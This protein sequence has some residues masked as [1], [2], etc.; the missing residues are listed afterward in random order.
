MSLITVTSPRFTGLSLLRAL[1]ARFSSDSVT[2]STQ[3]TLE[4]LL[5]GSAATL[6]TSTS[7]DTNTPL[8]LPWTAAT[9]H[10]VYLPGVASNY[11]S[12]PDAANLDITGD[13]D[14][15]LHVAADDWTPGA[16]Q[17]L[18]AKWDTAGG[19]RSFTVELLDTGNIRLRWSVDGTA[20][21]TEDSSV[22]P[23]LTDGDDLHIRI[24]L[25]AD[26]GSG[27]ADT[28][29]Y[30]STDGST[31]TQLGDVGSKG[32]TTSINSGTAIV[33]VGTRDQSGIP[34]AG[35]VH[36]AQIYSGIDGTKVLDINPSVDIDTSSDADAG[37]ASFTASTG[38]TVTVNRSG[39][40]PTTVVTRPVLLLD[41]GDDLV[42]LPA[43]LATAATE[44]SGKLTAWVAFRSHGNASAGD[45]ILSF[46]N[47]E[48]DGFHL[49][50]SNTPTVRATAG[51]GTNTVAADGATIVSGD[52]TFGALTVSE[53]SIRGYSA[54]TMS[55]ATSMSSVS[56]M[57][58]GTPRVGARAS[59][60]ANTAPI[61]V[62]GFGVLEGYAM[63]EAELEAMDAAIAA[64]A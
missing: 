40:L 54:G 26:N 16:D 56:G 32:A 22:A 20:S 3:Q 8:R 44:A 4:D 36:R 53:G 15:R 30:T 64:G 38:Q 24:T 13:I 1:T 55:A 12:V 63:T 7:E 51:D 21:T 27:G 5:G 34:F 52:L 19:N 46:E 58:T 60:V 62:I 47:D 49:S 39:L 61:E 14:I 11:V 6:G 35:K 31:W 10:Y 41:G 43:A 17:C 2:S 18:L 37:Q 45:R 57:A 48:N 9:G 29:F 23:T 59:S 25:D 28:T 42:G 33:E 50:I